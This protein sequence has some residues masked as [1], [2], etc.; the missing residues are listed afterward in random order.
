MNNENKP[1]LPFG[2]APLLLGTDKYFICFFVDYGY[3][4]EP[5][6]MKADEKIGNIL[7]HFVFPRVTSLK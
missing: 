1:P 5:K 6:P 3:I 4:F 7:Y 2:F